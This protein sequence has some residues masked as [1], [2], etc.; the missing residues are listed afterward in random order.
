MSLSGDVRHEW[1]KYITCYDIVLCFC[2]D[3][4]ARSSTLPSTNPPS[5]GLTSLTHLQFALTGSF[6]KMTLHRKSSPACFV[7]PDRAYTEVSGNSGSG[8]DSDSSHD[9]F[10]NSVRSVNVPILKTGHSRTKAMETSQDRMVRSNSI[11][12][13]ILSVGKRRKLATIPISQSELVD[14]LKKVLTLAIDLAVF[15]GTVLF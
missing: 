12:Q 15:T 3:G 13:S 6:A 14:R 10:I 8:G 2:T 7:Q 4:T 1:I 9:S 11:L 5:S